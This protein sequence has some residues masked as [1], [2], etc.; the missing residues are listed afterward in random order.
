M[1]QVFI[2]LHNKLHYWEQ[3]KPQPIPLFKHPKICPF[4]RFSKTLKRL[5]NE[6]I[7]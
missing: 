4:S 2:P 1:N 5:R 3:G 7:C 6:S